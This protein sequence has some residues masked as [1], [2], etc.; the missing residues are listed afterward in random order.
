MTIKAKEA[1]MEEAEPVIS[2]LS[3]PVLAP[4]TMTLPDPSWSPVVEASADPELD[5]AS[6]PVLDEESTDPELDEASEEVEVETR[7]P[8]RESQ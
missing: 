2:L 5:E 7:G 3:D 6:D 1:M 8:V 4:E